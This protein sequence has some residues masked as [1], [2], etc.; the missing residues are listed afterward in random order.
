MPTSFPAPPEG[1]YGRDAY[2]Q[3]FQSRVDHFPLFIYEG[4]AGIGK[5]ALCLRLLR[6]CKAAGCT[7]GMYMPVSPGEAIGSVLSRLEARLQAR[8]GGASDRQ[9][10]PFSRLLDLLKTHKI[11]L[12]LDDMESFRREDVVALARALAAERASKFRLL[13]ATRVDPDLPAIDRASVVLERVGA[14]SADDVR[15]IAQAAGVSEPVV[16]AL[17]EDAAR[18]G[19]I[20]QPITLRLVLSLYNGELP[21]ESIL[22]A[23]RARSARAFRALVEEPFTR[24]SEV[25]IDVLRRLAAVGRPVGLGV[26]QKAFGTAVSELVS[27]G[28]LDVI[29]GDV[30]LHR[31]VAQLV[32]DPVDLDPEQAKVVAQSLESRARER[33]EP[34]DVIRAGEILARAGAVQEAVDTLSD[35]WESVRAHGFM[36]AYLKTLASIPKSG[37]LEPRL[38]L[39]AARARMRRQNPTLA[40][41]EMERLAQSD[42]PW[43]RERAH[44]GLTVICSRIGDH[45][46]VLTA[47]AG[48]SSATQAPEVLVPAGI[49]AS[50]SMARLGQV[51]EAE[52]LAQSLLEKLDGADNEQAGE[53]HRLL[54]R[55]Y[56]QGGKLQEAVAEAQ[57]AAQAFEASGDLYHAATAFGFIGDLYRETGDFELAK[58]AFARFRGLA[59][60]WGDRDLMQIAELA[61]AWVSL[62]IGDL[63]HA[64]REIDEVEKEM[65]AAPSKRLR[66]YLAAARALL[67][68][69]R[70]HHEEAATSLPVVISE[71]REAGQGGV[72]DLLR[73]QLVRSLIAIDRL[74][75]AQELVNDAL[76]RLDPVVAAP[77]VATFLR[78][79]ALLHLRRREPKEALDELSQARK[80]FAQGGNRREEALTLHRIAHAALEEGDLELAEKSATEALELGQRIKHNRAVALAQEVV[81]R[82][83]L[84][85]DDA[86]GAAEALKDASQALRKLGD[87]L[88][89]MHVT[90]WLLRS[91]LASGDL[92]S[93]MRLGPR[94]REHADRLEIRDVRIRA[95][96]LTGVA[97]LRRNRTEHAARCFRELP[98]GTFSPYT[99]AFMWRLG[100]GLASVTG[101]RAKVLERRAKWA[102][103]VR[104]L[105]ESRQGLLLRALSQLEL[106]PRDR[107]EL[108][109]QGVQEVLGTEGIG[110]LD[111]GRYE[112]L[113]D[114]LDARL[115]VEGRPVK[116]PLDSF[117][118]LHALMAQSPQP[119]AYPDAAAAVFGGA[120]P[121][122]PAAAVKGLVSPLEKVL[123]K[124]EGAEISV[125]DAGLSLVLP[126]NHA[127]LIPRSLSPELNPDQRRMLDLLARF[128]TAP[129]QMIQDEF[130]MTRAAAR[131]ELGALAKGGFVEAIRDG[132]GQA[133]R[134]L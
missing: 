120:G 85:Q 64:A 26:A 91:Q 74:D 87:D 5:T 65:S 4:Q 50:Q 44:A 28:L 131:R 22:L 107:A 30:Y 78:E 68:A 17:G 7:Q 67:Q 105:P 94:L 83:L 108:R 52:R 27:K 19:G 106:P 130:K 79:S 23:Q 99:E 111:R 16:Q 104:K 58:E 73:A 59:E 112:V 41:G 129:V 40:R 118:L 90:E 9:G 63:T 12:F 61:D 133:F 47:Y 39:L 46:G 6:E 1:F 98:D 115:F 21:P 92:A 20:C 121:A 14:L 11:A 127:V 100:E 93:A 88:G 72:A 103:A 49:R 57:R 77:R 82:V 102:R 123:G 10:D 86:S 54:A 76:E 66:R 117:R 43:T 15:G 109:A 70:G 56:Q 97:L 71:W 33:S 51:S 18:S 36:E 132:R 80:L 84:M 3:R 29:E 45:E 125:G 34:I 25:E 126:K 60:A 119:M 95:I 110:W 116:V 81:G 96:V 24:Q 42:D 55:I 53:L 124:V 37:T 62:D 35:G 75:R 69:G 48:L 89:T 134:L 13:L 113:V 122:D 8:T 114:L 128:G 101:E 2:L 38:S 31:L 32:G